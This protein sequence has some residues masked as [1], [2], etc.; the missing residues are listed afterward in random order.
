ML[1]YNN[2]SYNSLTKL[3]LA[4]G[5]DRVIWKIFL[6]LPIVND[7]GEEN[8]SHSLFKSPGRQSFKLI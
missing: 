5:V 4:L 1:I 7:T 3:N 8:S 2:V 6:Q